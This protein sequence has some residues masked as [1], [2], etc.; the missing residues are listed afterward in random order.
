LEVF[1]LRN[2]LIN[3]YGSYV[4]SFI[5][6]KD[7]RVEEEVHSNLAAG[8]LW[9][10]PLIQLNP[11]FEAGETVD[12]LV[13]EGILHEECRR[14]FRAAKEGPGDPGK[15]LRLHRHQAEAIRTARAG[16]NYVLTTGTGSGKLDFSHL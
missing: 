5:R 4:G 11:S 3:D 10:D 14:I 1:E 6:I 15:T 8:L 16:H 13:D 9:P 2:R 7:Q 12:E